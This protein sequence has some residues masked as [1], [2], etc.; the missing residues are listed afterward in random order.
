MDL[1]WVWS[2]ALTN[3][4]LESSVGVGGFGYPVCW[5]G[6]GWAGGGLGSSFSPFVCVYIFN[7]EYVAPFLMVLIF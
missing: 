6:V 1:R 5:I 3:P 4:A 2:E 7:S